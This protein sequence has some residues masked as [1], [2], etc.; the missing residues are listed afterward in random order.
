MSDTGIVERVG[1]T[2][3]V[4]RGAGLPARSV[5]LRVD[6]PAFTGP[7]PPGNGEDRRGRRSCPPEA[8]A[9]VPSMGCFL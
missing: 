5:D 1:E 7:F 8:C 2:K 3:R 9:S 6:V 4:P